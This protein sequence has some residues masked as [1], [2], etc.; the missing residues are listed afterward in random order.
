MFYTECL[1][2]TEK[3]ELFPTVIY[4]QMNLLS[5]GF[6]LCLMALTGKNIIVNHCCA[7]ACYV[8]KLL[9]CLL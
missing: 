6:L 7:A 3:L 9:L 4:Y 1:I 5:S 8:Y 2:P